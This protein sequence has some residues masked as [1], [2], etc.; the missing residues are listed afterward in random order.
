MSSGAASGFLLDS[1]ALLWWLS[2]DPKLPD[3]VRAIISEPKNEIFVS[4]ASTWEI[5][6]KRQL[7]KLT[8]AESI[9]SLMEDEGFQALPITLVE[10]EIAGEL[11]SIHRDPFDRMLIA[12]AMQ[13]DLVLLSNDQHIRKYD[14]QV[15][16]E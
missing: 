5:T 2:D 14:V 15:F 7:G 16:W 13:N 4:A 1:H 11:P 12:Q 6:I 3:A 10:G 9:T 8:L